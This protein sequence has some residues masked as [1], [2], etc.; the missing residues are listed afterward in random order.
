MLD[1]QPD[2]LKFISRIC[3]IVYL[4]LYHTHMVTIHFQA[5]IISHFG[6]L[7]SFWCHLF[8]LKMGSI[9]W[10]IQGI[11]FSQIEMDS[12]WSSSTFQQSWSV[13]HQFYPLFILIL[14]VFG[15]L[16]ITASRCV[17]ASMPYLGRHWCTLEIDLTKPFLFP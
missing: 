2:F 17:N 13:F 14:S 15:S 11:Y 4:V 5:R 12:S 10:E 16:K 6:F 3:Y 7:I 1:H 9:A 8:F